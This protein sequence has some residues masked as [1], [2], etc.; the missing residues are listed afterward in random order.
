MRGDGVIYVPV[1]RR[2]IRPP[3][4]RAVPVGLGEISS[5]HKTVF[6]KCV[7]Y[8]LRHIAFWVGGK[9]RFG[10]CDF[11]ICFLRIEHA[12][13]IMVLG[14][15]D[16]VFHTRILRGS[17][18][19]IRIEMSWIES[20]L[21][22]FVSLFIIG[23]AGGIRSSSLAP[24]LIFGAETPALYYAPLTIR[25]PVHQQTKLIGLPLL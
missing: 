13:T 4:V 19:F 1:F 15:K 10:R 24:A 9:R 11:I 7:K 2:K 16:H 23:V 25:S 14:G 20:G 22:V 6:A 12:K 17:R 5:N 8:F 3:E 21:Q 18:P